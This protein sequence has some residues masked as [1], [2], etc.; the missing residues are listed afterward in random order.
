MKVQTAPR[1]SSSF[2]EK[3]KVLRASLETRYLGQSGTFRASPLSES[4]VE[5]FDV[6]GLATVFTNMVHHLG[7]E[8]RVI[9]FPEV[10]IGLCV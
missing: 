1:W 4:V 7:I 8:N 6:V 3:D 10:H 5:A 9:G 2:L